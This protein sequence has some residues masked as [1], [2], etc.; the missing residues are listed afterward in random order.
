MHVQQASGFSDS[1]FIIHTVKQHRICR[2]TNCPS[3]RTKLNDACGIKHETLVKACVQCMN[4]GN[5]MPKAHASTCDEARSEIPAPLPQASTTVHNPSF[6]VLQA[7]MRLTQAHARA[8]PA[9][10]TS[11]DKQG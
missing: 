5:G 1:I 8:L 11:T 3:I 9:I 4:Q 2:T 7:A 10:A 6:V